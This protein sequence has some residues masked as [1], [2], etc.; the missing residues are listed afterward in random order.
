M[1]MDCCHG[2]VFGPKD[3]PLLIATGWPVKGNLRIGF[4]NTSSNTLVSAIEVDMGWHPQDIELVDRRHLLVLLTHGQVHLLHS[5]REEVDSHSAKG[6]QCITA[7]P[8]RTIGTRVLLW[9]LDLE[10]MML[11]T[12]PV[13][14]LQRYEINNTIPDSIVY[15]HGSVYITDQHNGRVHVLTLDLDT[16]PHFL[17]YSA[18]VVDYHMPHGVDVR[19]NILAVAN[20][21]DNTV[22]LVSLTHLMG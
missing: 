16:K 21:G 15:R 13:T 14:L 4:F 3:L 6:V 1:P 12:A 5:E 2:A 9:D 17:G 10:N 22:K 11:S 7:K 20:Y 18:E 8:E 19:F